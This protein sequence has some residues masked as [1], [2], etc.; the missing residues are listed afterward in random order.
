MSKI[1]NEK[2]WKPID[3]PTEN[4]VSTGLNL[5]EEKSFYDVQ[6]PSEQYK[7]EGAYAERKPLNKGIDRYFN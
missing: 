6:H 5:P 2:L 4:I 7:V 3:I 1:W